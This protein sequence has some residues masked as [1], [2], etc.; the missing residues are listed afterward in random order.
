MPFANS[1]KSEFEFVCETCGKTETLT[2]DQA[3]TDGWDYPP[4]LGEWSVVSPRTCGDCCIDSTAW[5][6]LVALSIPY[7]ELSEHH[8]ATVKRILAEKTPR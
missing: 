5:W 4:F 1:S 8:Q 3:F 6:Q 2:N 7:K